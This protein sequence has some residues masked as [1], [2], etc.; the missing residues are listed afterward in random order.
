[1]VVEIRIY[2]RYDMDLFSLFDAGLPV[3]LMIRDAVVAYAHATP[4][5]YLI[6]ETVPFDLNGKTTLHTRINIPDTDKKTIYM[7]KHIKHGLRNNFCKMVLRNALIQQNLCGYFSDNNLFE[8]QKKNFSEHDVSLINNV[9]PCSA[10]KVTRTVSFAGRTVNIEPVREN[11]TL[12]EYASDKSRNKKDTGNKQKEQPYNQSE[13]A[14]NHTQEYDIIK[15]EIYTRIDDTQENSDDDGSLDD[16]MS[17]F[18]S[19]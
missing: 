18:D 5:H 11:N 7:L 2:K 6:D 10:L 19:I 1:M 9:I 13:D 4:L 8:L 12:K 17:S 15:P 16:F 14:G 3:P